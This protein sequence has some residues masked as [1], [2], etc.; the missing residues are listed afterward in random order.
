MC[1]CNH[2]NSD[3]GYVFGSSIITIIIGA[4][5]FITALAWKSYVQE[6]YKMYCDEDDKLEAKLCL[7]K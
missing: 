7:N 4:L 5:A 6:S 3:P 1:C 2:H